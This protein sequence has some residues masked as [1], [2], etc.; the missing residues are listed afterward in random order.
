M[1]CWR[2]IMPFL[3]LSELSSLKNLYSPHLWKFYLNKKI[4]QT[5]IAFPCNNNKSWNYLHVYMFLRHLI[6]CITKWG[7][8]VFLSILPGL[9]LS[10]TKLWPGQ[11]S[12]ETTV[13][14]WSALCSVYEEW[15][16]HILIVVLDI[17]VYKWIIK[18]L[19]QSSVLQRKKTST[20]MITHKVEWGCFLSPKKALV[21][22]Q[23]S[24]QLIKKIRKGC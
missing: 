5:Q 11:Q 19:T 7:S 18:N 10:L 13:P 12:V 20:Q 9:F 4:S 14:T 21:K 24:I 17:G 6:Y 1:S 8:L 3:L 23:V 22:V 15:V 16:Q 2:L